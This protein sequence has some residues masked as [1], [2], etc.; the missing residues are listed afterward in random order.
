MESRLIQPGQQGTIGGMDVCLRACEQLGSGWI[1]LVGLMLLGARW[2]WAEITRRRI[3]DERKDLTVE[4]AALKTQVQLLSMRPP[5]LPSLAQITQQ[6]K[7]STPDR[8]STTA[9][10]AD[11][12]ATRKDGSEDT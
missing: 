2:A 6:I 10:T 9:D 12:P 8:A 5:A 1:E 11:A 4:R 7:G 3:S